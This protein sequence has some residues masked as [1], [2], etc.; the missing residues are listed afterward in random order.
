[1]YPAPLKEAEA[2]TIATHI[3]DEYLLLCSIMHI[4][5]EQM[6][7]LR[8]HIIGIYNTS[9]NRNLGESP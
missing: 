3:G 7:V 1:M 6:K 5:I 9:A 2:T 4:N 8:C